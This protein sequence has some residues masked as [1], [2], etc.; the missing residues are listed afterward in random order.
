MLRRL[1][2]VWTLPVWRQA[3]RDDIAR[4]EH[5]LA[6]MQGGLDDLA[7]LP[8]RTEDLDVRLA[9][10][11]RAGLVARIDRLRSGEASLLRSHHQMQV[12]L[13]RMQSRL[14]ALASAWWSNGASAE[15]GVGSASAMELPDRLLV[16]A[17][18]PLSPERVAVS[19]AALAHRLVDEGQTGC[20]TLELEPGDVA[21]WPASLRQPSAASVSRILAL[22]G[23]D[24]L[25]RPHQLALLE[26]ARDRLVPGGWLAV[27]LAN[28][29]NLFELADLCRSAVSGPLH[30]GAAADLAARA[31]LVDV[32]VQH[33]DWPSCDSSVAPAQEASV[34]ALHMALLAPRRFLLIASRAE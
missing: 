31:G 16:D 23:F 10:L 29:E 30:A 14:D 6:R 3:M 5:S 12:E 18:T 9:G 2:G 11:E 33:C 22:D 21:T 28:P 34:S 17:R 19:H 25:Q 32:M 13:G 1:R 8:A 24:R 7:Q 27:G 4:L 20:A 26:L 15:P